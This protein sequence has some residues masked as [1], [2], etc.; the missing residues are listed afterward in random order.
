MKRGVE[1][2]EMLTNANERYKCVVPTGKDVQTASASDQTDLNVSRFLFF[3]D[4]EMK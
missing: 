3:T 2:V 1:L 4:R